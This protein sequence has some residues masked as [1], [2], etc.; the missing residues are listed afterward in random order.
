MNDSERI[1][2][3]M[4]KLYHYAKR[5]FI[6]ETVNR[7]YPQK[8]SITVQDVSVYLEELAD[9]GIAEHRIFN[10]PDGNGGTRPINFWRLTEGIRQAR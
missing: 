6:T 1:I 4:K 9:D 8:Q 10:R 5:E 3:A 2:E 7:L